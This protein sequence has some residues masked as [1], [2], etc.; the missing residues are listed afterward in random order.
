M[1][2]LQSSLPKDSKARLE[3]VKRLLTKSKI[4]AFDESSANRPSSAPGTRT[5]FGRQNQVRPLTAVQKDRQASKLTFT[6]PAF[7]T[8]RD[9]ESSIDE[10]P[11][12]PDAE[13][14]VSKDTSDEGNAE[15]AKISEV[16]HF[17]EVAYIPYDFAQAMILRICKDM[18]A[19][20]ASQTEAVRKIED[21][22]KSSELK[23]QE[24]YKSVL[25]KMKDGHKKKILQ[26]RQV[27]KLL[28]QRNQSSQVSDQN[29][30]IAESKAE[31]ELLDHPAEAIHENYNYNVDVVEE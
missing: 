25:V 27:I 2:S 12:E 26:Y 10:S 19:I 24:Y 1:S 23:K 28:Q 22:Y 4:A 15:S 3:F 11:V 21:H 16:S 20:R 7:Q 14:E 13:V 6:N 31:S 9:T 29:E 17:K 8:D 30:V 5:K 18:D